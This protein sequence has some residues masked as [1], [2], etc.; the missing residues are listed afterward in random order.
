LQAGI[1]AP[2][3][4]KGENKDREDAVAEEDVK[5]R[6]VDGRE[7]MAGVHA[8]GATVAEENKPAVFTGLDLYDPD[9]D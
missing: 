5:I 7:A 6:G 1:P 2:K 3:E 9:D 8:M 4:R